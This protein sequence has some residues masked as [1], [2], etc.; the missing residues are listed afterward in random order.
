MFNVIINNIKQINSDENY[1]ILVDKKYDVNICLSIYTKYC[2]YNYVAPGKTELILNS[3]F[4]VDD[5]KILAAIHNNKIC[6]IIKHNCINPDNYWFSQEK[7]RF[8]KW[9]TSITSEE[10]SLLYRLWDENDYFSE[11]RIKS[12]KETLNN[13]LIKN[14]IE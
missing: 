14:I 13:Y 9:I 2:K 4:G 5:W 8:E 3:S 10:I 6:N 11:G 7:E 1:I 12:A